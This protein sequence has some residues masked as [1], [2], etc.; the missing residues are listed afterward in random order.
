MK[1]SELDVKKLNDNDIYDLIMTGIIDYA[2]TEPTEETNP[3]FLVVLG[4]SPVPLKARI[5][6]MMELY[7]KG[8]GKYVLLSGGNGWHKLFKQEKKSFKSD[9]ERFEYMKAKA[10]KRKQMKLALHNTIP[11]DIKPASSNPKMRKRVI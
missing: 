6:K 4:C 2:S 10:N 11:D 7:Q 1:Y 9:K 3:D 5:V 8:F